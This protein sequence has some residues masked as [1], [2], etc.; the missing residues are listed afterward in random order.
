MARAS[1]S[2]G[3]ASSTCPVGCEVGADPTFWVGDPR[4]A[5]RTLLLLPTMESGSPVS[6]NTATAHESVAALTAL[7]AFSWCFFLEVRM[8]LADSA[9]PASVPWLGDAVF[10]PEVGSSDA[11]EVVVRGRD[12]Y[13]LSSSRP[14]HQNKGIV[15]SGGF[16]TVMRDASGARGQ[17]ATG[18]YWCWPLP[19]GGRVEMALR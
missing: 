8:V 14:A 18:R 12:G 16:A 9:L 17:R 10:G 2:F 6:W 4:R 3:R 5:P 19:P 15:E 7:S 1:S 13:E 11:V